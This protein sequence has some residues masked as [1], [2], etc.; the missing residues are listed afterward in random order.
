MPAQREHAEGP[1]HPSVA[2]LA[3]Q[4]N[5]T[6]H[7]GTANGG[8]GGAAS[9]GIESPFLAVPSQASTPSLAKISASELSYKDTSFAGKEAQRKRVSASSPLST[10][11][12]VLT[13]CMTNQLSGPRR[14]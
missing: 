13:W 10:R 1:Q 11:D 5:H 6:Q 12:V 3:M 7:H 14:D 4:N 9:S 8:G 2:L